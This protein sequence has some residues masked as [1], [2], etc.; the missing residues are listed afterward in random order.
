MKNQQLSDSVVIQIAAKS[1]VW[2]MCH[3][4]TLQ[5]GTEQQT[6]FSLALE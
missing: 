4:Y 6:S 3:K 1:V 2:Q 5:K